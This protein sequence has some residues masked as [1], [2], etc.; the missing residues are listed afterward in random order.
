VLTDYGADVQVLD[1][2][3]QSIMLWAR[4]NEVVQVLLDQGLD[5]NARNV[6]GYTLLILSTLAAAEGDP[7]RFAGSRAPGSDI[8]D[9]AFLLRHGADPNLKAK[10]GVTSL[11]ASQ[12]RSELVEL[13][14]NA[15]ARE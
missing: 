7:H 13:L 5:I 11:K 15:G 14:K 1:S 10:D 4:S 8:P 12:G 9:V 6:D 3:G 2:R